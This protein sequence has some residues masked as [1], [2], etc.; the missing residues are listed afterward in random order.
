MMVCTVFTRLV[1][2]S[3]WWR[4]YV[5]QEQDSR[6][7]PGGPG[8]GALEELREACRGA[9]RYAQ[10]YN[11]YVEECGGQAALIRAWQAFIEITFT[12]R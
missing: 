5:E 3:G 1:T 9:M 4:R 6:R 2:Q 12:R 7:Y 10:K 11:A 8:P